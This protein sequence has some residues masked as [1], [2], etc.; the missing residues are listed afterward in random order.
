M[1]AFTFGRG[2]PAADH[3]RRHPKNSARQPTE[4]GLLSEVFRR[5]AG[6]LRSLH[7]TASVCAYGPLAAELTAGH[8]LAGTIFGEG[9]PFGYMARH[10]T[11]ILGIGTPYFKS[12][13]QVHA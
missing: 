8:H 6:V 7:P 11:L 5:R 12:L 2:A 9:T 4:V 3:Y 10:R 1:P 13:T